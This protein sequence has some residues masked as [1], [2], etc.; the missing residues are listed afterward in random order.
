MR[1]RAM[2]WTD[3][4]WADVLLIGMDRVRALVAAEAAK[5]RKSAG[6]D[7]KS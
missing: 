4:G 7:P 1:N 6:A 3:E 5:V 2:R